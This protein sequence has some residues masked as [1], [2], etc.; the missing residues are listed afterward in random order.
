MPKITVRNAWK[1]KWVC[2]EKLRDLEGGTQSFT[3]LAR[4]VDGVENSWTHVLK[5][6]KRQELSARRGRMA[7]EVTALE[8]LHD[9]AGISHLADSNAKSFRDDVELYLVTEFIPGPD[10]T[11]FFATGP[12]LQDIVTVIRGVLRTLSICHSRQ[13]IHRDIK[14]DH[15]ILMDANPMDPILIDF[16]LAFNHGGESE[17]LTESDE[18]VGN[19]FIILP[20][21]SGE[22]SDKRDMRTDVTQVL[23][24]LF[25]LLT[26][27]RPANIASRPH[28]SPRFVECLAALP[29]NKAR[30]LKSLF[31]IGFQ[32]SPE[33]RWQ[34]AA[35]LLEELDRLDSDIAEIGLS[36]EEFDKEVIVIAK[37]LMETESSRRAN[38]VR[39]LVQ[40]IR[41][42]INHALQ[43]LTHRL[44]SEASFQQEFSGGAA[45]QIKLKISRKVPSDKSVE[46]SFSWEIADSFRIMFAGNGYNSRQLAVHLFDPE[47]ISSVTGFIQRRLLE[48][49]QLAIQEE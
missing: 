35:Q 32:L 7:V 27:S 1:Q 5:I 21:Y 29:E 30:V 12:S 13:V 26:G 44:Q 18:N 3:Y 22:P 40:A 17:T 38:S 33:S 2:G 49:V 45:N 36:P 24:L 14:P 28:K 39:A 34:S 19:R 16:G 47:A 37:R 41:L 46:C 20:E 11:N 25:F 8:T 4:T 10:L 42:A 43:S 6:L 9:C 48:F 31:E 15:V 23:G